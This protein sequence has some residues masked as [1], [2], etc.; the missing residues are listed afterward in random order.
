MKLEKFKRDKIAAQKSPASIELLSLFLNHTSYCLA[1]IL[2][3]STVNI[4][5]MV[6]RFLCNMYSYISILNSCY[7]ILNFFTI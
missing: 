3:N 5:W 4:C 6:F 1:I 2:D 7:V